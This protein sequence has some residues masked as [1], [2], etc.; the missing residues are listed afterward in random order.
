MLDQKKE[1]TSACDTG[2]PTPLTP[3]IVAYQAADRKSFKTLQARAALAGHTLT[4]APGGFMFSRWNHST[5]CPD[6]ATVETLL[7]RMDV[8]S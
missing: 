8:K 7:Q 6:L 5:H 2:H 4:E 3:P 1:V